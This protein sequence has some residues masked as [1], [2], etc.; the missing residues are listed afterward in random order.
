MTPEQVSI[1]N[2][3]LHLPQRRFTE[4][5]RAFVVLLSTK[6]RYILITRKESRALGNLGLRLLERDPVNDP[7]IP[8]DF[9]GID[10]TPEP[11]T[12]HVGGPGGTRPDGSGDGRD[13]IPG[14]DDPIQ[15]Y[16]EPAKAPR[17]APP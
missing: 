11:E 1:L 6:L 4:A 5:E 10:I 17:T 16:G 9:E 7:G 13:P 2:N 8:V 14:M 3:L 12:A 15:T